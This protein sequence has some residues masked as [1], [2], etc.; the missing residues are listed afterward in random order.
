MLKHAVQLVA[1]RAGN[2]P[3]RILDT[4]CGDFTWM[5]FCLTRIHNDTSLRLE[6][7]GVDIVPSLVEM[8]NSGNGSFLTGHMHSVTIGREDNG[9]HVFPFQV[10]DVSSSDSMA[11]YGG[12]RFDIIVSKHALIH[13]PNQA[14]R[15]F[16]HSWNTLGATYLL[17][18]NWIP[19][20]I[21]SPSDIAWGGYREPNL[22]ASPF[23]LGPALCEH[24]DHGLCASQRKCNSV[25]EL[26]RLPT[27]IPAEPR[28]AR[29]P[30]KTCPT[31]WE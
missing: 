15:G 8:L 17:L 14:I 25:L 18:D 21:G 2:R 28:D 26:H 24:A 30:A 5:P 27:A 31:D 22:H 9:V 6:Y 16:L 19:K 7:Q 29:T 10:A 3:V 12:G 20:G 13:A 23:F 4:P 11:P 1:E